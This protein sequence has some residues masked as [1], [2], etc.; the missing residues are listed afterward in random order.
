[1]TTYTIERAYDD[2]EAQCGWDVYAHN[3]GM[4]TKN[5]CSRWALLRDAKQALKDEGIA[6]TVNK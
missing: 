2:N 6:Y 3:E 4:T 1:M 5:W